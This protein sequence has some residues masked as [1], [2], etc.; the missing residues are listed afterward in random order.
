MILEDYIVV[1]GTRES[2]REDVSQYTI[3][4]F[5]VDG[6]IAGKIRCGEL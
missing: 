1:G 2:H 3:R 5:R 6:P 4:A